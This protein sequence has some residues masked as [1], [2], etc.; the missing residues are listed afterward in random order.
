MRTLEVRRH[1]MRTRPG[2]HLSQA[3]VTLARRVGETLGPFDR[4]V[5]STLPRAFETAIALGFAVDEQIEALG[6]MPDAVDREVD[7]SGGF[8]AFSAAVAR[9]KATAR[10]AR[11]LT[12]VF[13][14]I[15]GTVPDG[16]AALVISHGGIIEAGTIGCLPDAEHPAWGRGLDYCEGVRLSFAD[17]AFTAAEI[18]RLDRAD[19]IDERVAPASG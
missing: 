15:V 6:A 16:G 18:L 8:P 11:E 4:V 3:G 9:G 1:T 7:W 14:E 10:Y 19:P 13:R 2:K 5:T 17:G 12:T